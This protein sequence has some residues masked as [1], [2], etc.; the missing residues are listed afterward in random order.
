MSTF[1]E[2][3]NDD[4]IGYLLKVAQNALRVQMDEALR[5]LG[6][7]APQYAVLAAIERVPGL[8]SAALA[9]AAF[10]TAQTMQGIVVNLELQG[11][12]SRTADPAHGR[13]RRAALTGEGRR[14]VDAAH[15]LVDAVERRM[16]DGL[17]REGMGALAAMLA[18]CAAN[19][20][21]GP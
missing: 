5:P 17:D 20:G 12:L 11:L 7:T 8:S 4:R 6:I 3:P 16:L 14:T 10:V 18:R 13:I 15:R 1:R 2:N 19:L 21:A 9:R